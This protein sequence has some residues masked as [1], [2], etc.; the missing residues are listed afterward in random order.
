[1]QQD[2]GVTRLSNDEPHF[3]H[4]QTRGAGAE[5]RIRANTSKLRDLGTAQSR[6]PDVTVIKGDVDG[7]GSHSE[8]AKNRASAC[9]QFGHGSTVKIRLSIS[10]IRFLATSMTYM[11]D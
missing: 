11:V 1:V 6:Y 2:G 8:S 3:A 7:L 10:Y 5:F 9:E 4:R